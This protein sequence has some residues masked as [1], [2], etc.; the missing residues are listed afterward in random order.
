MIRD[1]FL[2]M[3]TKCIVWRYWKHF[4]ARLLYLFIFPLELWRYNVV[5]SYRHIDISR[6]IFIELSNHMLEHIVSFCLLYRLKCIRNMNQIS[7]KLRSREKYLML[8]QVVWKSTND[9]LIISVNKW[10]VI[11]LLVELSV[12]ISYHWGPCISRWLIFWQRNCIS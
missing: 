9:L 11:N 4:V 5:M 6:E 8:G 1:S 12:V 10:Q 2:R 7:N 3:Q